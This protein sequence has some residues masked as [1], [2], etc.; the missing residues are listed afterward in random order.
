MTLLPRMTKYD[1][2]ESEPVDNVYYKLNPLLLIIITVLSSFKLLNINCVYNYYII[3]NIIINYC[4]SILTTL[5][6][7]LYNYIFN[8]SNYMTL[9]VAVN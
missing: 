2:Q 5:T 9:Y 4:V 6:L 1:V 7:Y 3:N 8:C